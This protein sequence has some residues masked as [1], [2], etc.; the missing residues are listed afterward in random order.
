MLATAVNGLN[1]DG[2]Y[3]AESNDGGISLIATPAL[4]ALS[5]VNNVHMRGNSQSCSSKANMM[6]CK[7]PGSNNGGP[8]AEADVKLVSL[9]ADIGMPTSSGPPFY[10]AERDQQAATMIPFHTW[11]TEDTPSLNVP[12]NLLASY[13]KGGPEHTD[14]KTEVEGAQTEFNGFKVTTY[15]PRTA[16]CVVTVGSADLAASAVN[17]TAVY[18]LVQ[19]KLWTPGSIKMTIDPGEGGSTTGVQSG[20]VIQSI[21]G[22][23]GWQALTF[24]GTLGASGKA[25][26]GLVVE[27]G[28][29][30][31]AAA[32]AAPIGQEWSELL[33]SSR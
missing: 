1:V 10:S 8:T 22:E 7:T 14:C 26:F 3:M 33:L 4:P 31:I 9:M 30:S 2:L 21:Q 18:F 29:V 13:M 15:Q 17:G 6:Q 11:Q 5:Q 28:P 12:Q 20:P 19:A 23:P 25:S 24:H 16:Q 27:G 32:V